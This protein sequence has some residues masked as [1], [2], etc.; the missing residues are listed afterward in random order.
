ML[1]EEM[2]KGRF[3]QS[4]LV[5]L[6]ENKDAHPIYMMLMNGKKPGINYDDGPIDVAGQNEIMFMTMMY[7]KFGHYDLENF[8]NRVRW[9]FLKNGIPLPPE[10]KALAKESVARTTGCLFPIV[11]LFIIGIILYV[12][13]K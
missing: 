5:F 1:N 3:V 8:K 9:F 4:L 13:I 11:V 6:K 2:E 10:E 12:I 7:K